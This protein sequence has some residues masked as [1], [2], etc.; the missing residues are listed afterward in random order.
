ME[1]FDITADEV[2][3][4]METLTPDQLRLVNA[5]WEVNESLWPELSKASTDMHGVAPPKLP[6]TPFEV[7]GVKMTGGHMRLFYDSVNVELRADTQL[8]ANKGSVMPTKAGS[9]HARVGSGGRPVSLSRSNIVRN[10]EEVIHYVAF[11]K[12]GDR[13]RSLVNDREVQAA[14]VQKHGEGFYKAMIKTIEGITGNQ[15]QVDDYPFLS[16]VINHSRKVLIGKS[17]FLTG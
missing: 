5:V 13:L 2:M 16:R 9:L 11:S 12:A 17:C 15:G 1:G 7:N 4:I 8:S 3:T 6:A 10:L 14:I